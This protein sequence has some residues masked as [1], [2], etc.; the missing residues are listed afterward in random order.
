MKK[1]LIILLFVSCR[2]SV[3]DCDKSRLINLQT[4]SS[5]YGFSYKG[6]FRE[7]NGDTSRFA[8]WSL[9]ELT[10]CELIKRLE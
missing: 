10:E 6:L 1:L 9:P 5:S 4:D 7:N 8:Y 3:V 2:K